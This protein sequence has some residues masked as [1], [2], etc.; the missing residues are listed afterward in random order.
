MSPEAMRVLLREVL[1]LYRRPCGCAAIA[2]RE[3]DGRWRCGVCDAPL[4]RKSRPR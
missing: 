2:L 1:S 3:K 4:I